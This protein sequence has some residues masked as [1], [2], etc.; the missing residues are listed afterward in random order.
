M[1]TIEFKVDIYVSAITSIL[2]DISVSFY[3]PWSRSGGKKK[4]AKKVKKSKDELVKV[5]MFSFSKI[6]S[7]S[8]WQFVSLDTSLL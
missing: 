1:E 7:S 4:G 3:F 8:R 5:K 2:I 6:Q